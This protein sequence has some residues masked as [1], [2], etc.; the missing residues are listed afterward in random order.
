VE[1]PMGM[2][3]TVVANPQGRGIDETDAGA[4]ACCPGFQIDPQRDHGLRGELDHAV[5]ADQIR[6]IAPQVLCKL[7]HFSD[8]L[9]VEDLG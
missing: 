5:V 4:G 3:A 2:N 6:K 8:H 7:P 1:D 9:K